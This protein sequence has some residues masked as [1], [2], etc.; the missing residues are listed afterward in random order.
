MDGAAGEK[1]NDGGSGLSGTQ[2]LLLHDGDGKFCAVFGKVIQAD[3]VEPLKLPT[4]QSEPSVSR[5]TRTGPRLPPGNRAMQSTTRWLTAVLRGPSSM[6]T[7]S[8]YYFDRTGSDK[9]LSP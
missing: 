3:K 4:T 1:R 6:N 5:T 8:D 9:M 7:G 2:S